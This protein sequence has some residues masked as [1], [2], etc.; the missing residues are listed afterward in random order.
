MEYLITFL[1][2]V[3]TFLS[4]CM[5][6]LLPIYLSFFAG[7]ADV[8]ATAADAATTGAPKPNEPNAAARSSVVAVT[9]NSASDAP[10]VAGPNADEPSSMASA[11]NPSAQSARRSSVG[12]TLLCAVCF[13]LGFG[14]VFVAMGAFAGTLGALLLR[15]RRVL[16][17][18]CG[19]VVVALGLS[20]LGVLPLPSFGRSSTGARGPVRSPLGCF[21]FGMVFSVSW[22]PC[23]ST[24]LGSALSLAAASA[25]ATKGI[26]L[27]TCYS[28][29]LGLPF[30][31]AALAVDQLSGAF[32]W[33]KQHYDVVNKVCGVLLVVVGLLMASGWLGTWLGML[34]A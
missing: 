2:G 7:G 19:A 34:P 27:L 31:L 26:A 22:T 18:V 1:E 17:I 24:F 15:Y 30:V 29:G 16:D 6:P 5:L 10:N 32:G 13:V 21:I 25:S 3:V 11:P 33:V 8:G 12:H 23:V 4:P 28:L 14:L 9:A 20:Y